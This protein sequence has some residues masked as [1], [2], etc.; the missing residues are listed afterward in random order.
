M[1]TAIDQL[2]VRAKR[3][4]AYGEARFREAADCL[5]RARELGGGAQTG[6]QRHGPMGTKVRRE[7]CEDWRRNSERAL[8]RVPRL[9]VEP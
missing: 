8:A 2:H 7:Q 1:T 4:I 9:H 5:A 3:A 6:P